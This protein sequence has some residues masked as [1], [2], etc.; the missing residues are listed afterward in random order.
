MRLLGLIITLAAVAYAVH[1]YIGASP[2]TETAR[3]QQIDQARQAADTMNQALQLQ[4]E[5]L[6]STGTNH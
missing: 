2:N 1:I 4:Q 3:E 5:R 6:D